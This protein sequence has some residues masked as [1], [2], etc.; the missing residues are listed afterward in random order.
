MFQDFELIRLTPD[1]LIK[2][3]VC[4]DSE[5]DGFLFEDAK[6][7]LND[8]TSVTYILQNETTT[9]AYWNYINDKISYSQIPNEKKWYDRIAHSFNKNTVL[10]SYPAVKI[11][12]LGVHEDFNRQGI[13]TAILDYT[14]TLFINNNRTGCAFITVDA[15]QKS[16]PLY[17]KN[18]FNYLSNADRKGKTRLMYYN[19][20][21]LV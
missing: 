9:I 17:L 4:G 16:T 3:F 2:P 14:K 11:G 20:S 8:C 5:I 19:L 15:F 7:S 13:G 6:T 21:A 18:G 1:T 10:K 12:R